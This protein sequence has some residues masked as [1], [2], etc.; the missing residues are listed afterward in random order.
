VLFIND[1]LINY[2][3]YGD[4]DVEVA[5]Y[6][7]SITNEEL[8]SDGCAT[9]FLF[10]TYSDYYALGGID[11]FYLQADTEY[12]LV[13]SA[14]GYY[15]DMAITIIPTIMQFVVG[16]DTNFFDPPD[17]NDVSDCEASDDDTSYYVYSFEASEPIVIINTADPLSS[18]QLE[19]LDTYTYLYS[20]SSISNSP[21]ATNCDTILELD[22]TGSSP[23]GALINSGDFYTIVVT[24]YYD[25]DDLTPDE[26]GFRFYVLTGDYINTASYV[27]PGIIAS[28]TTTTAT[29]ATTSTTSTTTSTTT[30]TTTSTTSTTSSTV[31]TGPSAVTDTITGPSV[32]TGDGDS[33]PSAVTGRTSTSAVSGVVT[34]V[35]S[36]GVTSQRPSATQRPIASS[37]TSTTG[38]NVSNSVTLGISVFVSIVSVLVSLLF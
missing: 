20:G 17:T 26:S 21:P 12:T 22:D 24:D 8:E 31:S 38:I 34:G 14:D 19:Y 5:I 35:V 9:N 30:T 27:I 4:I 13:F 1:T 23:T 25:E 18:Y 3:T 37:L 7:G 32:V 11:H 29:T 10:G 28:S 36:S 15:G 16:N 6:S 33:G 2:G